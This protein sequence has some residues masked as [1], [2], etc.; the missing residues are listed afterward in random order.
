MCCTAKTG[1]HWE[2]LC[3]TSLPTLVSYPKEGSRPTARHGKQPLACGLLGEFSTG[4][5]LL[6]NVHVYVSLAVYI[7][8]EPTLGAMLLHLPQPNE[9]LKT[10]DTQIRN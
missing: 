3:L 4:V 5:I 7:V 10:G 2:V 1:L 9:N 6:G 8:S